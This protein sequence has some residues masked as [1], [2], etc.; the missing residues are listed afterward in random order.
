[1]SIAAVPTTMPI[2]VAKLSALIK[3][4]IANMVNL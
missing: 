1:M 4:V 3:D 2:K